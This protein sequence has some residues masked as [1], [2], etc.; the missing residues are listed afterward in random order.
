M[1]FS[2]ALFASIEVFH[3]IAV[4]DGQ[5]W[6]GST[7]TI[8]LDDKRRCHFSKAE[9]FRGVNSAGTMQLRER[10]EVEHRLTACAASG[11]TAR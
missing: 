11:L 1:D 3:R 9:Y 5:N 4:E 10:G 6:S 8:H 2:D 7:V